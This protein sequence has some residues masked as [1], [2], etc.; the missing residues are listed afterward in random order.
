MA[1][2]RALTEHQLAVVDLLRRLGETSPTDGTIHNVDCGIHSGFPPCCITFFAKGW[3]R[4][5][6]AYSTLRAHGETREQLLA[7]ADPLQREA[8]L[9]MD[10]Y[11]DMPL[12]GA[13]VGYI[14]CPRCALLRDFVSPL[15]CRGHLTKRQRDAV[16][17]AL[18]A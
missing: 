2:M 8:L 6:L 15:R 14:P 13:R 1:A 4:W 17:R 11:R 3:D 12:L 10:S 9:A 5:I 7:R 16:R 18:A